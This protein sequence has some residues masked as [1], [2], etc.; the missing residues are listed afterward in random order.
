MSENLKNMLP[1]Y[2][3]RLGLSTSKPFNCLS[4]EHDDEKPSMSYDAKHNRVKCFGCG[5]TWDLYDLIAVEELNAPVKDGKPEYSFKEAKQ[6]AEQLFAGKKAPDTRS[7]RREGGKQAKKD[8]KG[9]IDHATAKS[10]QNGSQRKIEG[11]AQKKLDEQ[12]AELI[13][14]SQNSL[15]SDFSTLSEADRERLKPFREKAIKY[16]RSR[17][18]SLGTAQRAK[19]GYAEQWKSQ[20]ALAHGKKPTAS[21]RI[22]IPTSRTSYVARYAGEAPEGTIKKMKE[23]K[24]HFFNG[25]A[26]LKKGP[27]FIVEGEFD[28]LS[29]MEA[30]Y[31]A[32][33]LGSTAMVNRF[34]AYVRWA[35]QNQPSF[36]PTLLLALDNDSAGQQATRKLTAE[37]QRLGVA[38]YQVQ[39][40]RGQKDANGALQAD[41]AAFKKDVAKVA[42]DPINRLQRWIDLF[43]NGQEQKA[44]PTGLN[45]L[46]K[47]LDG[48]LYEGLYG[49]G[50]ISSLGKTTFALQIADHIA[51]QGTPVLYFALEMGWEEMTSKSISRLTAINELAKNG[52]YDAH[53]AQ[54]TRS[55]QRGEWK[56]RYNR[57]QYENLLASIR[58]Y[59]QYA[60]RLIYRD[61]KE[62]RPSAKDVASAVDAFVAQTGERPVVVVDYL[63]LLAPVDP[64]AT[65]KS[66]VTTSANLLKKIATQH[67]IPVI[68]ISS[69]NR[70][71][72][73]EP[74]SMES[75]KESGD[76]EYS[77]DVLLGLQPEGVG[78]TDFNVNDAKKAD[79]RSV[80]AVVLK[81]RNG[82]T[83][84][85]L[86]FSYSTPFNLFMDTE[87]GEVE[88][89]PFDPSTTAEIDEKGRLTGTQAFYSYETAEQVTRKVESPAEEEQAEQGNLLPETDQGD[90][91]AVLKGEQE[92]YGKSGKWYTSE[93]A[94]RAAG[95]EPV[96]LPF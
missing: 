80:E 46:D 2:L 84:D 42:K 16:L 3:E 61:G 55:L 22:I 15:R 30:G 14:L 39:I 47:A 68:M 62:Q 5:A 13:R 9:V 12:R 64:R 74:A 93:E 28:A 83:G 51:S 81:N 79:P 11:T 41:P 45:S 85:V 23:G 66:A 87:D 48:G 25:A 92:V 76:I 36:Y 26:L 67:H 86:S 35:K 94:C 75:F 40:A 78:E 37:L 52:D 72:Y 63:Q 89:P 44:I 20:T 69:F 96:E 82:R 70:Q 4:P 7:E 59:E 50:A 31:R 1:E 17:G 19:L 58:Q 32:I 56:R 54:T 53:L 21:P 88:L 77:A 43:S 27:V 73:G 18:I 65:D 34:A 10:A 33:A 71:K 24:A 8:S 95:D 90:G 6:K 57:D 60:G 38:F 29:I 49:L 91:P